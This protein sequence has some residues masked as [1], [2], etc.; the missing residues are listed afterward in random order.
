M[1]I[2]TIIQKSAKIGPDRI[3]SHVTTLSVS[4]LHQQFTALA[5]HHGVVEGKWERAANLENLTD[6][7]GLIREAVQQ[8]NYHGSTVS[9]VLAHS[10]LAQQLIEVPPVK[11]ANLLKVIQREAQQQQLF[12]GEA[13]WTFQNSLAAKGVQRVILHLL[14]RTLLDRLILACQQN[15]LHLN[16][17]TPVSAV[18]QRQLSRLPLNKGEVALLAAETGGFTTV[19][20]GRADGQVL[21]V[22][23]LLTNWN[24]QRHEDENLER[25]SLDLKRT[26]SYVTQQF[27]LEINRQIWIFGPDAAQQAQVLQPLIGTPVAASPVEFQPSYWANESAKLR[28]DADPNFI[29]LKLQKAPQRRIFA[30]IVAAGTAVILAAALVAAFVLHRLAREEAADTQ[31]LRERAGQ[32]Q[33]QRQTLTQRNTELEGKAQLI[34][35]VLDGQ[36]PPAPAWMLG[37]LS[38]VVPAELVVTNFQ[39]KWDADV[40]KLHLAG[41]LQATGRQPAPT[42]LADAVGTLA[43]RLATGPFHVAIQKRSDRVEPGHDLAALLGGSSPAVAPGVTNQFLIEGVMR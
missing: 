17:V 21:L 28:P 14:P 18:L 43:D 36:H 15:G 23:T 20:A 26:L 34:K 3:S 7:A 4:W 37:Y 6:L 41:T 42:A 9:L 8:T 10:R 16:S 19:V 11:G 30:Q 27:G 38:E 31:V 29:G 32:L 25:V 33:N 5:M 40:W 12:S 35:L 39:V 24:S 22:R 1:A 2:L 13:A